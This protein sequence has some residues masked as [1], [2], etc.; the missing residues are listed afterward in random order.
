VV[1]PIKPPFGGPDQVLKYLARY[2][3]RVAISTRRLLA[4]ADG[5][6]TFEWKDYAA[7]RESKTMTLERRS[8]SFGVFSSTFCPP[9]LFTF[10]TLAFSPTANERKNW[11]CAAPCCP[12]RECS[13]EPA[14]ILHATAIPF[15]TS[16]YPGDVL[17]AKRAI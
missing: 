14:Q 9:A 7:G 16:S 4:M 8:S 17:S 2:T 12:I 3:H 13:P 5:R 10:A 6:V 15:R 11:P 1:Y